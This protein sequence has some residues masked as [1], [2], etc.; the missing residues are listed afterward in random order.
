MEK[1]Q[2]SIEARLIK[3]GLHQAYIKEFENAVAEGFV[4]ESNREEIDNYMG[5]VKYNNHLEVINEN[6][7][8]TRL[9]IVSNSAQNNARSELSLNDCMAKGP[10][11]S[12]RMCSST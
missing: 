7:S 4:V 3:K 1:V 12:S 9:R 5:P 6:S 2:R 8:S 10:A 11:R